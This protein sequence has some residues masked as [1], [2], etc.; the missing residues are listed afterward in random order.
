MFLPQRDR[1]A[2]FDG[3]I[4]PV[5]PQALNAH[6]ANVEIELLDPVADRIRVRHQ[7]VVARLH[8]GGFPHLGDEIDV[9][10]FVAVVHALAERAQRPAHPRSDRQH[11]G[12]A[13]DRAQRIRRDT[14]AE[15]GDGI[16]NVARGARGAMRLRTRRGR[17]LVAIVID[18]A[19][20]PRAFYLWHDASSIIQ[21]T[22]EG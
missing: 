6:R 9:E 2:L 10:P 14:I 11:H 15:P 22:S 5:R 20:D 18:G 19:C 1:L 8:L 4:D 3:D 7:D 21:R 16:G 13:D 12:A 17:G